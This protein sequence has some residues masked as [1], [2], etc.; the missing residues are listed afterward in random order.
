MAVRQTSHSW[1][2]PLISFLIVRPSNTTKRRLL[3]AQESGESLQDSGP[4]LVQNNPKNLPRFPSTE[5]CKFS[6]TLTQEEIQNLV[7]FFDI[8]HRINERERLC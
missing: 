5:G 2:R 4:T 7:S 1:L 3:P 6:S 8:L